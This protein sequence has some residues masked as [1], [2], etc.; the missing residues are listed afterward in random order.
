L[1]RPVNSERSY[2]LHNKMQLRTRKR[3]QDYTLA[4]PRYRTIFWC[5]SWL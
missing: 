4:V 2:Q 1:T 3:E 5:W